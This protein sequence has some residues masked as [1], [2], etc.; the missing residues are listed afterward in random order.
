MDAQMLAIPVQPSHHRFLPGV[1]VRS[2][3]RATLS[4]T[5]PRPRE[6]RHRPSIHCAVRPRLRAAQHQAP[7]LVAWPLTT[8]PLAER[9]T[10][11]QSHQQSRTPHRVLG[12]SSA[13]D[14]PLP[15]PAAACDRPEAAPPPLEQQGSR[16]ALWGPT[17]PSQPPAVRQT[18]RRVVRRLLLVQSRRPRRAAECRR[19]REERRPPPSRLR[20]ERLKQ[21]ACGPAPSYP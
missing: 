17:H 11:P 3:S 10:P 12:Y 2:A 7:R 20:G 5:P 1:A 18:Q 4:H 21:R 8:P 15:R 19:P 14:R 6:Q 13:G 9:R 16:L